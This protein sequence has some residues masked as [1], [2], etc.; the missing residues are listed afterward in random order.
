MSYGASDLSVCHVDGGE[1][2]EGSQYGTIYSSR[3]LF[4]PVASVIWYSLADTS[5]TDTPY[6]LEA[7]NASCIFLGEYNLP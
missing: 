1:C 3:E 4:C 5:F 7:I 6:T 2:P